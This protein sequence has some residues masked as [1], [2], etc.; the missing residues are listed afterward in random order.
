MNGP[1]TMSFTAATLLMSSRPTNT[2][3]STGY[4]LA[5]WAAKWVRAPSEPVS[6]L[7]LR[8]MRSLW[9]AA[10]TSAARA[11]RRR[12][13]MAAD[14]PLRGYRVT[15]TDRVL[16]PGNPAFVAD[17]VPRVCR[18]PRVRPGG[19]PPARRPPLVPDPLRRRPRGLP[20]PAAGVHVPPPVHARG[21]GPA[22]RDPDLARPALDR[23]PGV[24]ALGHAQPRAARPHPAPPPRP[25]GV[26]AAGRGGPARGDRGARPGAARAGPRGGL[27]RPGPG[28]RAALLA[29]DHLRADRRVARGPRD[30]QGAVRRHHHACTSRTPPRRSRRPPTRPCAGSG[31]TCWTSSPTAAPTR[32]TT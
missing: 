6:P 1:T 20:R 18:R 29:G 16:D 4:R 21:A 30:D 26:H 17:P 11:G 12:G 13:T 7:S 25:G 3:T 8:L 14:R 27:R 5:S 24:R 19:V 2:P 28:L 22:A 10:S 23:V 32:P 9:M 15:V 31:G